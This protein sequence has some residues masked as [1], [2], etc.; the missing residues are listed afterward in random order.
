VGRHRLRLSTSTI[1][2]QLRGTH[3]PSSP[4]QVREAVLVQYPGGSITLR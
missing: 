2:K 4:G 3:P 1:A